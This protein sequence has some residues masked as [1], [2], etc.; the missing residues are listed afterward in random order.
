MD[1]ECAC[2]WCG[3]HNPIGG[4]TY[5]ERTGKADEGTFYLCQLCGSLFIRNYIFH[6][7]EFPQA[8]YAIKAICYVGNQLRR[9]LVNG[10]HQ[11]P[12]GASPEEVQR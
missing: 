7:E 3:F 10:N 11:P 9:D 6:W 2:D 5:D 4:V 8:R 1:D 12:A